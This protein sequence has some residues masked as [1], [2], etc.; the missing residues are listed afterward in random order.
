MGFLFELKDRNELLFYFGMANLS[1]SI[2]FTI[3]SFITTIEVTGTNAWYKPI[4]FALSIG[5]Y[6]LT[7]G[8]LMYYLPQTKSI[9]ICSWLI[10]LLL[11]F[12]IIYIGIQAGRGQLSHFNQSSNF[13]NGMYGLMAI[14]ATVVSLITLYI[15]LLF[16]QID[17]PSLPDYYVWAIRLGLILFFIFSMEGFIMGASLSHTIG[18]PD[19][20]ESIPFLNWSRKYGDPRVAHF[21]GMHAI[22][23]LPLLAY[24]ILKDIRLTI[25][26][27]IVYMLVALYVLVQAL[28]GQPFIKL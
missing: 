14:A 8:W 9:D 6:A 27:S 28:N 26:V 2:L 13:Y 24:Y 20:G 3:L 12:E 10:V 4:K 18:G 16:F 15:G 11:G 5:L 25:A 22:Q 19:G 17:L 1:L 23:V 7:M 21:I